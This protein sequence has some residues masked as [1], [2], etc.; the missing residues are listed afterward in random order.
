MW[1]LKVN[2]HNSLLLFEYLILFI[3]QFKYKNNS[4]VSWHYGMLNYSISKL[5]WFLSKSRVM[6]WWSP[7]RKGSSVWN[8]TET[9]ACFISELTHKTSAKGRHKI[10]TRAYSSMSSCDLEVKGNVWD[11]LLLSHTSRSQFHAPWLKGILSSL[12]NFPISFY[13]GYKIQ[14]KKR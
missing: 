10:Y 14:T 2:L 9:R 5:E 3:K 13:V 7:G 12:A 8:Y 11:A 1:G 4:A 6:L